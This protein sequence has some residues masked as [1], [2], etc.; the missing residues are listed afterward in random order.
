MEYLASL[1][2]VRELRPA[3]LLPAH[4]EVIEDPEIVIDEIRRAPR[5][6]VSAQVLSALADGCVTVDEIV[7]RI[8][9]GISDVLLP[10]PP[11]PSLRT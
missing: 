3:R 11:K 6:R 9:P 1:Q 2:R 4:G 7:A 10:P 8:Y 5:R